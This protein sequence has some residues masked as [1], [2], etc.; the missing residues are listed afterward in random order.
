VAATQPVRAGRY[1]AGAQRALRR[2]AALYPSAQG[3]QVVPGA[4]ARTSTAGIDAYA[5]TVAYNGLALFGLTQA[6]DSLAAIPAVPIGR[7][8]ADGRLAVSDERASG[9]AVVGD[10][11]A[12]LAVH[13]TPTDANDLRHDFGW[14][15][16]K[17]NT[18]AG[19]VD[20]LAPRPLTKVTPNSGGP[21]LR[22]LGRWLK[23]TGF[24]LHA[25][26]DTIIVN[27]A[28]R[29][30]KRIVRRAQFRWRLTPTGARLR[31]AGAHKGDRFR[32]L[33]WTPAGTGGP[34]PRGL[35]AGAGRWRFDRRV[36]VRRIPG[37]HSGPVEHLDALEAQLL[38]PRSGRFVVTIRG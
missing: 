11:R 30:N 37:Y 22:Y 8:P 14:L 15:A 34:T 35:V 38:A 4:A 32:F 23:P 29:A 16:L 21:A 5:H 24:G 1:L 13:K 7:L 36:K 33:A 3:L 17:R 9:I 20:L 31:V 19:W 18:P 27:G 26:R 10:G 6:L 2:L 25:F 28:Y 12:W